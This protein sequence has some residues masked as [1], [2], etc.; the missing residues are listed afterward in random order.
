MEKDP[1]ETGRNYN[2][3]T[4][5]ELEQLNWETLGRIRQ[6]AYFAIFGRDHNPADVIQAERREGH[7]GREIYR[8]LEALLER[9]VDD[10]VERYDRE[11]AI[12][13][14]NALVPKEKLLE[15]RDEAMEIGHK[16]DV[17]GAGELTDEERSRCKITEGLL[18][19]IGLLGMLKERQLTINTSENEWSVDPSDFVVLSSDTEGQA[20]HNKPHGPNG[21]PIHHDEEML[22]GSTLND[23]SIPLLLERIKAFFGNINIGIAGDA[24]LSSV[25]REELPGSKALKAGKEWEKDF[26]EEG[27]SRS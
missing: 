3:P 14:N 8:G 21:R 20:R 26:P 13:I 24:V 10:S 6:L 12:P 7:F 18:R 17:P 16:I 22:W 11:I 5:K 4:Q 2:I 9:G 27:K 19:T 23:I 15:L 25:F 1:E